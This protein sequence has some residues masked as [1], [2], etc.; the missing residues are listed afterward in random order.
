MNGILHVYSL[1]CD[2]KVSKRLWNCVCVVGGSG[3]LQIERLSESIWNQQGCIQ[4]GNNTI[5]QDPCRNLTGEQKLCNWV[6]FQPLE[7]FIWETQR[8]RGVSWEGMK[9]KWTLV[10]SIMN[11]IQCECRVP[12]LLWPKTSEDSMMSQN[13][14]SNFAPQTS[15]S[16]IRSVNGGSRL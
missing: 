2:A 13:S 5:I 4:L 16:W 3:V 1:S 15:E 6:R 14:G 8:Q 11:R 12:R 10:P 7:W 9:K